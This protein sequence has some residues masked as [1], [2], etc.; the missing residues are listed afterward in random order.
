MSTKFIFALLVC[1][2]ALSAQVLVPSQTAIQGTVQDNS[3]AG[4]TKPTIVVLSV[5][6]LVQISCTV[7]EQAWVINASVGQ[8]LYGCTAP[9]TWT[10]E[11]GGGAANN[12]VTPFT[13]ATSVAITAT[14]LSSHS[15]TVCYNNASPPTLIVTG[16]SAA[17]TDA[18]TITASWTGSLT[19][20][21]VTNVTGTGPAGAT[22][23]TG[24]TG[25]S[26]IAGPSGLPGSVGPPG[27]VGATGAAGGVGPPGL[28]GVSNVTMV[29]NDPSVG[30]VFHQLAKINTSGNAV[31][32]TTSD[33]AIP[34]FIVVGSAGTSGQATLAIAGQAFC[35]TDSGGATTIGD[36]M[37]E[38]TLSLSGSL[39]H[40]AGA[41]APTSGWVIG[42]AQTTAAP[43]AAVNVL[44][45]QGY[46][47]AAGGSTPSGGQSVF[48]T[49]SSGS[50]SGTLTH[51]FNS[52]AH[53]DLCINSNG[54]IESWTT[55]ADG[56]NHASFGLGVNSDY[57]QFIGG[58]TASTTCTA[59]IGGTSGSG[60]S[61][62]TFSLGATTA[63]FFHNLGSTSHTLQ[64]F[65][66]GNF[67][68]FPATAALGATTDTLAFTGGLTAS[69]TCIASQ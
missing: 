36:F 11:A 20:T 24:A 23:N 64:C 41:T 42:Q 62:A 2:T 22:G 6:A 46:N 49:F 26:G 13:S 5:S 45:S 33:T 34:V 55:V 4:H 9:D 18:N 58:L 10:L 60:A 31:E 1:A 35:K 66:S 25:P 19:G 39:C 61:A 63:S 40:D 47:A 27:A 29:T 50:T 38:S 12:I 8:N 52:T 51:N 15:I 3:Q 32:S 43:N 28:N 67:Q 14:N 21:C 59:T 68:V 54:G 17:L 7:G 57:F 48:V 56:S 44:L 65:N 16:Y 37:V 69:T 53:I 30:T